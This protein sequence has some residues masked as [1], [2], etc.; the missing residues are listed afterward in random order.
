M[1]YLNAHRVLECPLLHTSSGL[2]HLRFLRLQE[3]D[4]ATAVSYFRR[5]GAAGYILGRF[6]EGQLYESG[7]DDYITPRSCAR[8]VAAYKVR[9]FM[10]ESGSGSQHVKGRGLSYIF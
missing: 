7:V 1:R 10:C 9:P 6:R 2:R 5:A 8:A 4:Y 3:G